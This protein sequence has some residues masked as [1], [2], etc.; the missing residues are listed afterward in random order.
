[1]TL[2]FSRIKTY[3]LALVAAVVG[4]LAV[5]ARLLWSQNSRLRHRAENAE[6]KARRAVVIAKKD[7]EIDEQS[8]SRRAEIIKDLDSGV[9][10]YD[11]NELFRDKRD[12]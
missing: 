10:E 7:V 3:G 4:V 5:I 8:H 11:P 9:S 6:A 12:S 2:L 1:M